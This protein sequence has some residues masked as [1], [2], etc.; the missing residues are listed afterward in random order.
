MAMQGTNPTTPGVNEFGFLHTLLRYLMV[1]EMR[2]VLVRRHQPGYLLYYFLA[3]LS[4][5]IVMVKIAS[6]GFSKSLAQ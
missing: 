2:G 6:S 1:H 4:T 5:R 3:G